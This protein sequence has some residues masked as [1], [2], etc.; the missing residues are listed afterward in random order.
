MFSLLVSCTVFLGRLSVRAPKARTPTHGA[1]AKVSVVADTIA[2]I[3]LSVL[4]S[5]NGNQMISPNDWLR[6][7]VLD[8]YH[9]MGNM[10]KI[11]LRKKNPFPFIK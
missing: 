11:R 1:A 5:E 7:I 8:S 6:L 9:C 4:Q 3:I 2:G 10:S